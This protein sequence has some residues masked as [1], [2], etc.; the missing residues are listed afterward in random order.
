MCVCCRAASHIPIIPFAT[1]TSLA[2]TWDGYLHD[3]ASLCSSR[4][5]HTPHC[6]HTGAIDALKQLDPTRPISEADADAHL[7]SQLQAAS[8]DIRGALNL[9]ADAVEQQLSVIEESSTDDQFVNLRSGA[10][11]LER[12][13]HT[14]QQELHGQV[15]QLVTLEDTVAEQSA[16]LRLAKLQLQELQEQLDSLR[17]LSKQAAAPLALPAAAGSSG[18]AGASE[19][20]AAVHAATLPGPEGSAGSAEAWAADDGITATVPHIEVAQRQP[21]VTHRSV[22]EGLAAAVPTIDDAW[23]GVDSQVEALLKARFFHTGA[24]FNAQEL[25]TAI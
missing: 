9:H 5:P 23:Q 13:A 4:L 19:P 11:S 21:A 8:A 10:G 25:T 2:H 16:Q 22:L 3:T 17:A 1:Q 24:D 6:P 20:T 14:Q 12:A 18:A 15:A 7:L